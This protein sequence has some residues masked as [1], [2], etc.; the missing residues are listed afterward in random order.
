MNQPEKPQILLL[1]AGG[2]GNQ[3]FQVAAALNLSKG[4]RIELETG[5][6]LPRR[7]HLGEAEIESFILPK[8]V[9]V[10][11]LRYPNTWMR[12]NANL[13]LRISA[14]SKKFNKFPGYKILVF[15]SSM[16]NLL[17]FK[18]WRKTVAS[19]SLGETAIEL[20][21]EKILLIG[22]FQSQKWV[23]DSNVTAVM[24]N[25]RVLNPSQQLLD[26]EKNA[27]RERPLIVHVRLGDYL[28]EK[29]FGIPDKSYY[30]S[31]IKEALK[32]RSYKSLWLF[33]NDLDSAK[34]FLP[35]DLSIPIREIGDVGT[36]SAEVLQ[37]M[38]LGNGYVLGNSTFSWWAAFLAHDTSSQVYFPF[39]WFKA[40]HSP[41]NLTPTDWF[42]IPAWDSD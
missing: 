32:H 4:K 5:V 19:D 40:T 18:E 13:F 14:S 8:N 38:R 35:K 16:A 39:P 36:S 21:N 23:I 6:A 33:S 41:E 31:A 30:E 3:L 11:K 17:Y 20:P 1:V 26:L 2:L 7:N 25:L 42:A 34:N 29:S 12:K 22:L 9:T 28:S 10:R 15:V 24:R 27:I 37:A